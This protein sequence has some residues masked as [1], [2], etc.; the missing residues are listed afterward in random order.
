[1]FAIRFNQYLSVDHLDEENR[2]D[3]V[4]TRYFCSKETIADNEELFQSSRNTHEDV[5]QTHQRKL[6]STSTRFDLYQPRVL[7]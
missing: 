3:R 7:D 5:L 1:M 2:F 4:Q 6:N